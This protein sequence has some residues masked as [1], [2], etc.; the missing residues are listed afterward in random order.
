MGE[1]G[2]EGQTAAQS[3]LPLK[4]AVIGLGGI[5]LQHSVIVNRLPNTHVTSLVDSDSR[6]TRAGSKILPQLSFFD[7]PAAMMSQMNPDAAFL[8][9]PGHTHLDLVRLLLRYKPGLHVFIEKPLATTYHDA[10]QIVE[11]VKRANLVTMVG[12]QRRFRGTFSLAKSLMDQGAIGEPRFF[13]SHHF[14]NG[15]LQASDGWRF[16]PGTGGVTIDWGVHL[17]AMLQWFFGT[18]SV[19]SPHRRRLVS[20]SVEDYASAELSYSSGL[21]GTYEVCWSMRGFLSSELLLHVEGE[22]GSIYV[23][24]EKL[25][26]NLTH[27]ASPDLG[28]GTHMIP[29]SRIEPSVPFLF[30]QPETTVQDLAFVEAVR[31]RQQPPNSSSEIAPIHKTVDSILSASLE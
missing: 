22:T 17:L 24:E 1:T 23:T 10:I 2:V 7:D 13:R 8:C 5:G 20:S 30:G 21:H 12:H 31:R 9:T 16:Q 25:T 18:A 29:N 19:V 11:L 3:T 27:R 4:V 14:S 26:L 6:L 15:V 28:P